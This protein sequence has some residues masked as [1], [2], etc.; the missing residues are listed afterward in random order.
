[1]KIEAPAGEAV[2]PPEAILDAPPRPE[3]V[4]RSEPVHVQ[5]APELP[6]TVIERKPGWHFVN[7]RE[8]W[9]A[10]EVLFYLAWRDI[11]VRY[12]Q[13]ALGITWAFA[14]PLFAMLVFT[15]FLGNIVGLGGG[16]E[17]Y[18]LFVFAGMLPWTFFSTAV[19]QA[20]NSLIANERLITKIYFPRLL[21]PFSSVGSVL[22]DFVIALPL[23]AIMALCFGITPT[24][25]LLAAPLAVL[26]MILFGLGIGA[27][28]AALIA[29]QR[30]F[31]YVMYFAVQIW[32]FATPAVYRPLD[33]M[34]ETAQWLAPLNPAQG[35]I[36][37]FRQAVLGGPINWYSLGVSALTGMLVVT[38]GFAYFRRMERTFADVI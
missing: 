20:G 17:N 9:R 1:M 38:V 29:V 30:D 12:K 33:S 26:L 32:M 27:L 23:L 15:L 37:N 7:V 4:M 34:S 28:L 35:L 16:V 11:K 8:M 5:T 25:S 13:T 36:E 2:G 31:R 21:V 10:R 6:L 24:W 18:A 14:Q 19:S 3:G 22:F